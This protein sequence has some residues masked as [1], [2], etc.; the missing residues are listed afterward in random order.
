[1]HRPRKVDHRHAREVAAHFLGAGFVIEGTLK[2]LSRGFELP[3]AKQGHALEL[4]PENQRLQIPPAFPDV[5]QTIAGADRIRK[6]AGIEMSSKQTIEGPYRSLRISQL[7]AQL[8][9]A[10]VRGTAFAGHVSEG[11]IEHVTKLQ[12]E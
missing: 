5:D 12:F 3:L 11:S 4:Q 8:N 9:G 7:L 6:L 1:M 10:V 2:V